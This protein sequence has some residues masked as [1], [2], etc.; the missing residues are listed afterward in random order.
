MGPIESELRRKLAEAFHPQVLEVEN[1]SHK[2]SV[3]AN[4]ETHFKVTLVSPAFE[5]KSLVL[6]HREVFQK[7]SAEMREGVHALS[8]QA[9]TPQEWESR[10]PSKSPP[11]LGGSKGK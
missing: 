9:H 6:R 2:H 1:E 3:P 10:N 5:G 8:L 11:C 4:S 7:L